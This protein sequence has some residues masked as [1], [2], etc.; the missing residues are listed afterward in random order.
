M[1][2]RLRLTLLFSAILALTLFVSGAILYITVSRL[3]YNV[4]EDSLADQAQTIIGASEFAIDQVRV[5]EGRITTPRTFAQTRDRS[6]VIQ[7]SS[8]NLQDFE[9]PLSDEGLTELRRGREWTETAETE[10]GRVLVFNQPIRDNDTGEV[11]GIIQVARSIADHDESLGTIRDAIIVGIGVVT[12]VAFG[13]S[14]LLA[15]TAL[16]PINRITQTAQEIGEERDFS[17]RVDYSGPPDELGRLTTTMNVMLTELQAAFSHAER[18][19][20]AQR[21]FAADASHELRTPLTT[22]RGNLEL[23]R[24]DPP[25]S[26]VDHVEVVTDIIEECERL[27]RLVND[28]MMLQRADA[29]WPL[30][31]ERVRIKPVIEEICRQARLIDPRRTI[32]CNSIADVAIAGSRDALK[33]VVLILIDNAIK[34][35][36]ATEQVVI[37]VTTTNQWVLITVRDSGPGIDPDMLPHIFDRFYRGDLARRGTGVGLGLAIAKALIGGQRGHLEVDT[38]P[39]KGT[40]FTV[41]LPRAAAPLR[42]QK[43]SERVTAERR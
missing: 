36:P 40:I 33:Q 16:R 29:E 35:T 28:L 25:I 41:S 42:S 43:S 5:P 12:L 7:D 1:S 10:A 21:R 14:W 34:Y 31:S 2:I 27:I 38:E 11:I 3:T 23:L 6:G 20:D 8:E 24:H 22:I 37:S 9:I 26:D 13:I 4:R 39:G 19:L 18:T 30:S 32:E 17:Q 15:G